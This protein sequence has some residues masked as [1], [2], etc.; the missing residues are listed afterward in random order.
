MPLLRF[1]IRI[2][3][4]CRRYCRAMPPFIDAASY[5]TLDYVYYAAADAA[6]PCRADADAALLRYACLRP[7]MLPMPLRGSAARVD[8]PYADADAAFA[9]RC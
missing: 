8:M 7:A 2:S 5:A 4:D 6:M 9:A 3:P 1:S